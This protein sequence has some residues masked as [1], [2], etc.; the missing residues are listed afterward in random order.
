MK[1][2]IICLLAIVCFASC[3]LPKMY[4]FWDNE[5]C[6]IGSF[7]S[8]DEIRIGTDT[9]LDGRKVQIIRAN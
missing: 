4:T 5:R 9:T 2:L 1:K 6:R 7:Y 3:K 8:T